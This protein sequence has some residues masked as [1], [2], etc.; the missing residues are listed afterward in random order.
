MLLCQGGNPKIVIRE[1]SPLPVESILDKP[2][3]TSGVEVARQNR[4][5]DHE[6]LNSLHVGPDLS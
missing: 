4:A 2:I 6:F 3:V 5:R 1:R